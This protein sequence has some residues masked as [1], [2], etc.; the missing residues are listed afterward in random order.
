MFILRKGTFKSNT[1]AEAERQY[2]Q[3][4]KEGSPKA[5]CE[6]NDDGETK[7]KAQDVSCAERYLFF[8]FSFIHVHKKGAGNDPAPIT[9]IN[10]LRKS[11]GV[12]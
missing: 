3:N 5:N 11:T 8:R 12:F 9:L 4:S 2:K 1:N 10:N 6:W 7:N